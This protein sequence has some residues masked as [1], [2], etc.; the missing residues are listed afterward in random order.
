MFVTSLE[1]ILPNRWPVLDLLAA[2]GENLA[3]NS[4]SSPLAL[5]FLVQQ[6][7]FMSSNEQV[8]SFT[9]QILPALPIRALILS[10]QQPN[11]AL[12]ARTVQTKH[13]AQSR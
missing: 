7:H 1:K 13:S 10:K 4:R 12:V 6:R 11:V 8:Q 5:Q 9:A 3:L 2:G